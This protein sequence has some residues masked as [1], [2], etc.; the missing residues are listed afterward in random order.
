MD[1]ETNEGGVIE[2][3]A[4]ERVKCVSR[5]S[6]RQLVDVKK[7]IRNRGSERIE[8][9]DDGIQRMGAQERG[10]RCGQLIALEGADQ[11]GLQASR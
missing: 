4:R 1:E 10:N 7:K 8:R 3:E 9:N 5:P 6:R 2:L 11:A